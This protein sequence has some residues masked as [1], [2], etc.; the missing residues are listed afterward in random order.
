[1]VATAR[2]ETFFATP[3]ILRVLSENR[4]LSQLETVELI[5]IIRQEDLHLGKTCVA[6]W[7]IGLNNQGLL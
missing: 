1:V 7:G 6:H 4:M 5:P 3:F 2:F